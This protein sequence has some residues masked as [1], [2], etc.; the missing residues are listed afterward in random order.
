MRED[1]RMRVRSGWL[2]V[3]LGG[4]LVAAAATAAT[5]RAQSCGDPNGDGLDVIDASNVLR[6]AVSL[7]SSCTPQPAFCDVDGSGGLTV[8]DS[9]NVLRRA[10]GLA[11]ADDCPSAGPGATD[12]LEAVETDDGARGTLTIGVAPL[13]SANA[14]D[15]ISEDRTFQVAFAGG[16]EPANE[17]VIP[18][19][20]N[21]MTVEFDAGAASASAAAGEPTLIVAVQ[22]DQDQFVS[23]FFELPLAAVSG[24]ETLR[25][26]YAD[27]LGEADFFLAFATRNGDVVSNYRRF[28]QRPKRVATGGLQVSLA[29]KPDQD[30]D[31]VLVE[32]SG[33]IISFN[34]P[35]SPSGGRLDLDSN[36]ECNVIDGINNENIVYPAGVTPPTGTYRV[37]AALSESCDG[38]GAAAVILI[39]R[40]AGKRTA[41]CVGF[42]AFTEG[43]GNEI[44]RFEIPPDT[45]VD[46]PLTNPPGVAIQRCNPNQ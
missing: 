43:V 2:G 44:A 8:I 24:I 9:A 16:F 3:V 36:S 4:V 22:D 26:F 23:G 31:L 34:D 21:T 39:K 37:F 18:G 33:R 7:P 27:D 38:R 28:R 46:L 25:L 40:G 45:P 6:A 14:P 11:G 35:L 42:A 41:I 12:F 5:A 1:T 13:P 19:G 30:L 17:N 10:V 29:W 32:P 15:T 20:S